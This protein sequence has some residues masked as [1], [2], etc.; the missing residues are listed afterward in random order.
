MLPTASLRSI[1]EFL[2]SDA[3]NPI[4]PPLFL[5]SMILAEASTGLHVISSAAPPDPSAVLGDPAAMQRWDTHCFH[6]SRFNDVV[7]RACRDNLALWPGT[8]RSGDGSMAPEH[9]ARDTILDVTPAR[10]ARWFISMHAAAAE[11]E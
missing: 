2:E 9:L 10:Q 8:I 6:R 11:T 7:H 1:G 5:Q 4:R 3:W